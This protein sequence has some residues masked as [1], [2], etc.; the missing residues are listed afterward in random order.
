MAVSM[1]ESKD[2]AQPKSIE[3]LSILGALQLC[4]HQV[5]T[6]LIIKSDY[7]LV[8]E[9]ILRQEPSNSVIGNIILDIKYLMSHFVT[10]KCSM[11][12]TNSVT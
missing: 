4:M 1:V 10:M 2:V 5:I 12:I 6:N 11:I 7:L 3:V 8:V 9:E